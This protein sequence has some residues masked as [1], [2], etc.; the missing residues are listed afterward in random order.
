VTNL[1]DNSLIVRVPR[2]VFG[3]LYLQY[4]SRLETSPCE[5]RD[6]VLIV[7]AVLG[8][9]GIRAWNSSY[10]ICHRFLHLIAAASPW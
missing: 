1:L 10:E 8:T 5:G 6:Y 9:H 7:I 3:D 4:F 2:D